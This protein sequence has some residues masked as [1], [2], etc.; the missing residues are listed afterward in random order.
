MGASGR[1]LGGKGSQE[2]N[3]VITFFFKKKWI[4][5]FNLS[6]FIVVK[7]YEVDVNGALYALLCYLVLIKSGIVQDVP[8]PRRASPLSSGWHEATP[9]V[10]QRRGGD[11][12]AASQGLGLVF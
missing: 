9:Q 8:W 11:S 4:L 1:D 12:R 6:L 3:G 5:Y 2:R 10:V 7:S